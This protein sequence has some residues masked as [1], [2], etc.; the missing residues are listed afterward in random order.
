M[1]II[2][3][4]ILNYSHFPD[5]F[6]SHQSRPVYTKIRLFSTFSVA[7]GQ[8]AWIWTI[9]RQSRLFYTLSHKS[10]PFS[11][12]SVVHLQHTLP[13]KGRQFSTLSVANGLQKVWIWTT[14]KKSTPFSTLFLA[15]GLQKWW[16]IWTISRQSTTFHTLPVANGLWKAWIWIIF[17][18]GDHF[19]NYP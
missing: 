11:T 1:Y 9:S 14:L 10:T 8:K 16:I 6:N 12:F 15:N 18:K 3:V 5:I 13:P 4:C 17:K 7:N 19:P 2:L